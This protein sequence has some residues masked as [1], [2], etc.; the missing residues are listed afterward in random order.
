MNRQPNDRRALKPG[1]SDASPSPWGGGLGWLFIMTMPLQVT[2][3]AL[4][5]H[6]DPWQRVGEMGGPSGE[7][8]WN[9]S[10]QLAIQYLEAGLFS[11]YLTIEKGRTLP[12]RIG[13][14]PNGTKFLQVQAEGESGN[15]LLALARGQSGAHANPIG[16]QPSTLSRDYA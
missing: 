6:P 10:S 2:R 7:Q 5:Q 4:N 11:Y 3:V 1:R 15:L 12:V 8:V 13:R 9:H 14:A 16:R